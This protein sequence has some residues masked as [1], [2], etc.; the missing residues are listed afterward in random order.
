MFPPNLQ[1]IIHGKE[2]AQEPLIQ[3]GIVFK[4]HTGAFIHLPYV[5]TQQQLFS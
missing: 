1:V 2:V 4:A 3:L 5:A